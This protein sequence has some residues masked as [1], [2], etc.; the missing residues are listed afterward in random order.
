MFF[1][2]FLTNVKG[3]KESFL[4]YGQ[5]AEKSLLSS[6]LQI[7]LTSSQL[8]ITC[9]EIGKRTDSMPTVFLN[10]N[11]SIKS[12]P[13]LSEE[14]A[15]KLSKFQIN[16]KTLITQSRTVTLPVFKKMHIV[17]HSGL[18]YGHAL[19]LNIIFWCPTVLLNAL[20]FLFT[21]GMPPLFRNITR[22]LQSSELTGILEVKTISLYVTSSV[23]FFM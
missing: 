22:A 4:F 15:R 17:R 5:H 11:F 18:Q 1:F 7:H 20:T 6:E 8:Q 3:D 13:H 23:D 12:L 2:F 19:I 16:S 14:C 9:E 10:Y 21:Q